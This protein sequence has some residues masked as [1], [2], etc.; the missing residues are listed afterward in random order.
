MYSEEYEFTAVHEIVHAVCTERI[1]PA[2]LIS[3]PLPLPIFENS[4]SRIRD[5][6]FGY[7]EVNKRF[8]GLTVCSDSGLSNEQRLFNVL[9]G[10]VAELM[11]RTEGNWDIT[12]ILAKMLNGE[13]D[14]TDDMEQVKALLA[15][16][17]PDNKNNEREHLHA[18]TIAQVFSFL[19]KHWGVVNQVASDA[20]SKYDHKTQKV[21]VSY[22]D[23][24][25]E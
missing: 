12:A 23:L 21:I 6:G 1:P 18:E 15:V 8:D 24:S 20:L 7:D 14:D 3:T 25:P 5:I 19:E 13:F 16:L 17:C 10:K 4:S 22:D 9:G 11:A 2:P